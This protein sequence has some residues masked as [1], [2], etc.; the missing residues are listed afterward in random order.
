MNKITLKDKI[1]TC[2]EVLKG[3]PV[4]FNLHIYGKIRI[5]PQKGLYTFTQN[6]VFW[7]D[8]VTDKVVVFPDDIDKKNIKQEYY[9]DPTEHL[10][11]KI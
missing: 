11:K 6:C 4:I 2:I 10:R 9:N 1:K 5:K 8:I 3:K 7:D